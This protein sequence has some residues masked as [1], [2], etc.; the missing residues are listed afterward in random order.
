VRVERGLAFILCNPAGNA[1][2]RSFSA[3]AASAS[4]LRDH[5]AGAEPLALLS[6]LIARSLDCALS[7]AGFILSFAENI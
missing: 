5:C 1:H 7:S 2:S 6:C 3:A 4:H